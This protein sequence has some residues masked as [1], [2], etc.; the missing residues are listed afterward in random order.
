VGKRKSKSRGSGLFKPPRWKHLSE[1]ISYRSPSEARKS[2]RQI[3]K[4]LK[5]VKRKDAALR[6]A[7]ALQRAAN[8]T[9]VIYRKKKGLSPKE[10][11]EFKEISKIYEEAAK[12]AWEIYRD[13]FS[14]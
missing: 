6:R 1:V 12:E 5:E 8:E 2:A 10:R 13:K 7:R 3:L 9:K 11:R 4:E 14:D